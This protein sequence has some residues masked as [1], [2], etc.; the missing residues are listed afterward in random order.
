MILR[1]C[2]LF[3]AVLFVSGCAVSPSTA[4][5]QAAAARGLTSHSIGT[6]PALLVFAKNTDH[7]QGPVHVY[8]DGDGRPL[9]AGDP[10][11]RERLVL[12]LMAADNAT[13]L[14]LGRPCYYQGRA[15][16]AARLWTEARYGETV[17]HAMA[18][19]LNNELERFPGR[20]IV[21]IGYSGGGALA[22]L[23]APRLQRIDH[24]LT[25]AANLDIGAWA[26]H[27]GQAAPAASLNPGDQPA[28][29]A[30]ISQ[31][32]LFGAQDRNVPANLMRTAAARSPGARVVVVP[33]Y[34]HRCCWSRAWPELL[35]AYA[36]D[37]N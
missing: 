16:C 18:T 21:L 37:A 34:N 23:L 29:P 25:V 26:Q 1:A 32:H 2:A 6:D 33:D 17:V 19:A 28:L 36:G 11:T 30:R 20:R 31:V 22:M 8:L 12:K 24:I 9:P 7:T 35:A 5:H 27:H 14:L 3:A 10:T 13:A 4:F 15:A